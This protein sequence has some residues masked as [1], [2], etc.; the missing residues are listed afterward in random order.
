M[1]TAMM[2]FSIRF[3]FCNDLTIQISTK[4]N[5]EHCKKRTKLPSESFAW[6]YAIKV[7]KFFHEMGLVVIADI[8]K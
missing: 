5:F 2:M 7:L 1:Q 8:K 3:I 6:C 4:S